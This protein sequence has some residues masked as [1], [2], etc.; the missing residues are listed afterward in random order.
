MKKG[1]LSPRRWG[2]CLAGGLT[3][4][5]WNAHGKQ[6]CDTQEGEIKWLHADSQ[7]EGHAELLVL[8]SSM[9]ILSHAAASSVQRNL[10]KHSMRVV[11]QL[12]GWFIYLFISYLQGRAQW[13]HKGWQMTPAAWWQFL[14]GWFV[15]TIDS[16]CLREDKGLY[17]NTP[18]LYSRFHGIA[19]Y[20]RHIRD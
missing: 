7:T 12:S 13:H 16:F 6:T 10:D 2:V 3:V 18:N 17:R 4:N 5:R 20:S 15:T 8:E 1:S 9:E 19:Y 11:E 14:A